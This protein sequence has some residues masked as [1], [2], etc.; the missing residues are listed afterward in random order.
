MVPT[1]VDGGVL[2]MVGCATPR[3]VALSG[4]MIQDLKG[5]EAIKSSMEI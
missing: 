1:K 4:Y 3:R 2:I 5:S